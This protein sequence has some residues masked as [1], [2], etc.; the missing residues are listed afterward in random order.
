[1]DKRL[2]DSLS[3]LQLQSKKD[4]NRWAGHRVENVPD[5]YQPAFSL[6]VWPH[7]ECSEMGTGL[8]VKKKRSHE[9][10][11]VVPDL[12]L[13]HITKIIPFLWFFIFLAIKMSDLYIIST[14]KSSSPLGF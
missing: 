4:R 8:K 5:W 7:L 14:F 13:I 9:I 11:A 6:L 12:P 3:F 1:M 10:W 2:A